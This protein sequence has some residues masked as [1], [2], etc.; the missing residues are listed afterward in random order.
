[1]IYFLRSATI[2][3]G[4]T[5]SAMAF[6]REIAALF[7]AK[8]GL[9]VTIAMP[10]GGQSNRIGWFIEYENLAALD[11]TQTKLLKDAEYLEV[12]AKGGENF[13]GGSLNDFIW[14]TL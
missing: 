7:K 13:I 3:P 2:A 11:D 8:T 9:D 5:V 14:R 1:M 6:A 10:V 12:T 4:K